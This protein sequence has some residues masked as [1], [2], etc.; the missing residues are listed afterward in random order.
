MCGRCQSWGHQNSQGTLLPSWGLSEPM[1][2]HAFS[3]FEAAIPKCDPAY[4]KDYVR[5]YTVITDRTLV[6]ECLTELDKVISSKSHNVS[7]ETNWLRFSSVL[8][9]FERKCWFQEDVLLPMGL[10]DGHVFYSYIRRGY[11]LKDYGAGVKHGEFTHRLQWHVLMR[12]ITD[13][14]T[15]PFRKGWDHSPLE[16]YV[17]LGMKQNQGV[18]FQL[19]DQPGDGDFDHPDSFHQ[20]VLN[21]GLGNIVAAVSKRETKRR[22]AFVKAIHEYIRK[23]KISVPEKFFTRSRPYLSHE[24]FKEFESWIAN[25][26]RARFPDE[27]TAKTFFEKGLGAKADAAYLTKKITTTSSKGGRTRAYQIPKLAVGPVY[28]FSS[29]PIASESTADLRASTSRMRLRA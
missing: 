17:S 19:L 10:L 1:C 29:N 21:S 22:E 25:E 13:G 5:L 8:S 4:L 28:S 6:R 16:L 3:V 24:A 26:V 11:V 27:A 20:W 12:V 7:A 18:W 15:R 9:H 23:E 14:F 2:S